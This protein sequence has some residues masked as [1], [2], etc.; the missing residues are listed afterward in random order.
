M[1]AQRDGGDPWGIVLAI[2]TIL[3]LASFWFEPFEG[4]ERAADLAGEERDPRVR[5]TQGWAP[6]RHATVTPG[7]QTITDG[8]G[9]CTTNFVFTD[10]RGRVYL[11]QAAH[12]ARTKEGRNGCRASTRPLGTEVTFTTGATA[13]DVGEPVAHGRL[14]YNSWR[15]MRRLGVRDQNLCA[16]NDFA[17][18][19]LPPQEWAKV[20]PSLPYWG[21]PT[22]LS[23]YG[24]STGDHVY[25]FGRSS[26]RADD[27]PE[28]RQAALAMADR[29]E[30]RGWSHTISSRSPGIPGDSGSAYVDQ[31]GRAIGTLST[32]RF[33]I[34]S[35]G[36]GSATW[37][38]SWP[39]HA[40]TRESSASDSS[41]APSRSATGAPPHRS[42]PVRETRGRARPPQHSLNL[43]LISRHLPGPRSRAPQL[44]APDDSDQHFRR[45]SSAARE[46]AQA[47]TVRSLRSLSCGRPLT[48]THTRAIE[49]RTLRQRGSSP[50][51]QA[52]TPTGSCSAGTVFPMPPRG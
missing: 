5:R 40:G 8:A 37:P 29:A 6:V 11:G 43:V 21:G 41:W 30:T 32:L 7:I 48:R 33:G 36:T 1:S 18:V 2:V 20:N 3:A 28:S 25:G 46:G 17:L 19:R 24:V 35:C 22:G 15:T 9:Q 44:Q 26:L 38:G 50:G 47:W 16:Y 14:A 13:F 51:R 45:S 4:D 42:P 34:C 10:A 23:T 31:D 27:S 49:P 39:M 12:C 52:P